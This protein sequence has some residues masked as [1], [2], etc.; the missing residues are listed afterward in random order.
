MLVQR[1]A[2]LEN[3]VNSHRFRTGKYRFLDEKWTNF[4]LEIQGKDDFGNGNSVSQAMD[5][6]KVVYMNEL[7]LPSFGS[8]GKMMNTLGDKTAQTT[9]SEH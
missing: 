9:Q 5:T 4:C 8:N 7:N 1:I 3:V 2:D 6:P